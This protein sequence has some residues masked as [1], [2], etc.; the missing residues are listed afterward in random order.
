MIEHFAQATK[1]LKVAED[2]F[3]NWVDENPYCPHCG[4]RI[5][6]EEETGGYHG[7]S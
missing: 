2:E 5:T 3:K 4:S 6:Q 7:H 1:A